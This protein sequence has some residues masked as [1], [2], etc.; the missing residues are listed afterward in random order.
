MMP[1]L[2][3]WHPFVVVGEPAIETIGMV[4]PEDVAVLSWGESAALP[5][6]S[7]ATVTAWG[8]VPV[9]SPGSNVKILYNCA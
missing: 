2:A 4:Y 8:E 5:T 6:D 3:S 9:D 7:A 1:I